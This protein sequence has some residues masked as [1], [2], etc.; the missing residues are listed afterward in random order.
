VPFSAL[1]KMGKEMPQGDADELWL[2]NNHVMVIS[3]AGVFD[4]RAS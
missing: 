4:G 3:Q 1:E 2:L